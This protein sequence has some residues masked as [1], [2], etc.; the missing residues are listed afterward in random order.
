VDITLLY[1]RNRFL[2]KR[3]DLIFKG[4]ERCESQ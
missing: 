3:P 2:R 1:V 4:D